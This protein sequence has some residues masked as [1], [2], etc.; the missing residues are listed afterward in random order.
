MLETGASSAVRTAIAPTE[1]KLQFV[2]DARNYNKEWARLY[3]TVARYTDPKM[4]YTDATVSGT[5]LSIKAY[6]PSIAEVGR[7]LEAHSG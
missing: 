1:A 5:A 4:I 2:A 3:D 6:A 7:Y